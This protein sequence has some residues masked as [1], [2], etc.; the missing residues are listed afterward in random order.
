MRTTLVGG[1]LTTL[2]KNAARQANSM[3]LFETG[4]RFLANPENV[5]LEELDEFVAAAHGNDIQSDK[6]VY[7]Q[8][9]LA[10]LV[11][12][13]RHAEN[14][15]TSSDQADF[16][17]VK[18]DIENLFQQANGAV[19]TFIPTEL[20]LLHPGQ[21]AG[22]AVDGES[23]GFIG[24][25]NPTLQKSLDLSQ[26]PIVFELSLEALSAAKVPKA[27]PMSR[28]PQVRR[29]I[30]LLVD[31][32]VSYQSIVDVIRA[33]APTILRDIKIFDIY[34]GEKLPEG[35]K[36]MALGLI[37]QEFSRTLED[38]EVES[39]VA[40]IVAALETAHGAVLRV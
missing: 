14:W 33:E 18:A 1:L 37:L 6:S 28:F 20:E 34:Q 4:L 40:K 17:S 3:S 7:Q 25:L 16:Y 15:N 24:A 9:M 12:G 8:N 31:D 38:T 2:V 30:A 22:I 39:V 10:G 19:V 26:M 29:D 36:S 27:S 21:R 13:R 23:V 32:S 11:A 5:P 35:K